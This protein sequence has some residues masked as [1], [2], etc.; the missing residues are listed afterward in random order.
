MAGDTTLYHSSHAIQMHSSKS[1]VYMVV[2]AT[3][4]EY[5]QSTRAYLFKVRSIPHVSKIC[6]LSAFYC[7]IVLIIFD[8]LTGY[9]K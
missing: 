6:I 4:A 7:V 3:F 9:Y 8:F 1:T 5:I 2:E